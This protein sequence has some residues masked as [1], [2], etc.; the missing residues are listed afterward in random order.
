MLFIGIDPSL[1]NT[2]IFVLDAAGNTVAI[3]QSNILGTSSKK[4]TERLKAI[5][6]FVLSFLPSNGEVCIGYEDYSFDSVHRAF[7]LAELGGAIK[8]SL[9]GKYKAMHM[10]APSAL[11][12]FATGC[13]SAKKDAMIA[14]AIKERQDVFEVQTGAD[15]VCDAYFLALAA[16]YIN[17]PESAIKVNSEFVRHRLT[18]IRKKKYK[19][20]L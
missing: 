20:L 14:Q 10:F 11:K 16:M 12:S 6:E 1:T 3:G 8:M 17:D 19:E 13:G 2:G 18:V 5:S 15:D 4:P 7:D 9:S